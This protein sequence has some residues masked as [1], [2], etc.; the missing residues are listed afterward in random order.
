MLPD[1]EKLIERCVVTGQKAWDTET[2]AARLRQ[3]AIR[4]RPKGLNPVERELLQSLEAEAKRCGDEFR[5]AERALFEANALAYERNLDQ[6]R[7]R[8]DPRTA[9]TPSRPRP[10]E[11]SARP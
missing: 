4:R 6:V 11:R 1:T 8:I 10:T 3:L 2:A 7:R 5:A 9:L